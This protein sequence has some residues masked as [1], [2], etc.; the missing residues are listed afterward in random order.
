MNI[1]NP[2]QQRENAKYRVLDTEI[3]TWFCR[4]CLLQIFGREG[5]QHQWAQ[6][7]TRKKTTVTLT[8]LAHRHL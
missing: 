7:S 2:E 4:E 3:V 5:I 8:F 1:L 6:A